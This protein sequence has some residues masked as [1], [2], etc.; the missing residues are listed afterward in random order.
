MPKRRVALLLLLG[1]I[2]VGATSTWW[3]RRRAEVTFS[4]DV[5]PILFTKCA[6][7]HR[8]GEAGPFSLLDFADAH[9]HAKQ[10][11]RVTR[12]RYMPPW[13]PV[14]GAVAYA[15]DRSLS[16]EQIGVVQRWVAAGAPPGK[17]AEAPAPPTFDSGWQLGQPDVIVQ[18]SEPYHL[19]PASGSG[20]DVYRNFVIPAP[21]RGARY[22]KAWEFRAGTRVIHHAILN[23]DR[24][25]WARQR[26][27]EDAEP[28]FAGMDP[29][30]LQSPDGFYLVWTPGKSPT[31]P[32]EGMAWTIDGETDMVLQLH[33][34]PSGK[35]ELVNP[36]IGLFFAER[37][38]TQLRFTLR[39]GDVPID[40]PAGES[41]YFIK[42]SYSL[43][44]DVE[45]L[46]LF[47]H[48][49]YLAQRMRCWATLPDGQVRWL[50]R[51]DDWDPSWQ[52]E[53]VLA[54]PLELPAGSTI[55]ME[56]SYD[57]SAANVRNPNRPPKEVKTGERTVDEMGNI[58][59]QL[60]VPSAGDKLKLRESKYRRQL[61]L[62][63]SARGHY[64]LAN[65][66]AEEGRTDD[67]IAHY[68]R[69]VALEPALVPAHFN[70]GLMLMRRRDPKSAAAE[71]QTVLALEPR[72]SAA[73]GA[74]EQI[75]SAIT[76]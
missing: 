6:P 33:M 4:R 43:P 45:V 26:D 28:G 32:S 16:D 71:F 10:M 54:R 21:V 56:F 38:P 50:L 30:N 66:L 12:R 75:N 17:L 70:L 72:N 23:L 73:R 59:F 67:A 65:V 57:N 18:L 13:K 40:I 44:A 34:R 39:I 64:N 27:A 49:H 53:Y 20:S 11:A 61:A 41:N 76:R 60:L 47:P 62:G 15:N 36:T 68:Q 3:M 9:A 51:I 37:P 48:A 29:G 7:C 31:P 22:V 5:A 58:T 14:P 52:E 35:A 25:R 63:E 2:A 24:N 46:S 69:A 1:V 8:P 42:D 74:L 55:A 19:P